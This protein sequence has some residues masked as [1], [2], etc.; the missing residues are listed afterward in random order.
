MAQINLLPWREQARVQ[1]QRQ[2]LMRLLTGGILMLLPTCF[3]YWYSLEQARH[4]K[5][6]NQYLQS[7][8]DQ[9]NRDIQEVQRLVSRRQTLILRL[10][11]IDRL[12]FSQFQVAHWWN[13]LVDVMPQGVRLTRLVRTG[14]L[15]TLTGQAETDAHVSALM[16]NIELSAWL[17]DPELLL[18]EQKKVADAYFHPMINHFSLSLRQTMPLNEVD[19]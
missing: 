4:Q 5:Q 9:A 8:I 12:Q 14:Q 3:W 7:V 6:R 13:E 18:I 17:A 1:R 16:R 19:Q 11:T 10:Q 2:A 15:I